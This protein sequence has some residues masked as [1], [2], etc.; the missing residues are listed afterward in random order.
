M[1]EK[2]YP[3]H[4]IIPLLYKSIMS[5]QLSRMS[6]LKD[7]HVI[8]VTDLVAC[9]HKYK[10]RKIYPELTVRFEPSAITGILIHN[11]IAKYLASEGYQVEY[12]VETRIE[13]NGV[14]YIVKGRIDA[15]N[16]S[17]K[18]VVEIKSSRE[19]QIEPL[20][21]HVLQLQIYMTILNANNGILLY[22]TPF[23]I[24]EY[25]VMREKINVEKMVKALLNDEKHPLWSWECKYCSFRKICIYA[26]REQSDRTS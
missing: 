10:L 11:G 25:G 14:E 6:E 7:E 20:Q 15:Y 2:F 5:E 13:I 24:L 22:I 8:Y 21:H 4:V 16:P 19:L 18:T 17:G 9:T 26:T 12:P 23:G 3:S 1:S